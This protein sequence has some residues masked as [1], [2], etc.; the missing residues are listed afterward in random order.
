MRPI[1]SRVA[2]SFNALATSSACARLSSWQGPAMIEIGKSLPNFTDPAAT[3]GAAQIFAFK[4]FVLFRRDHAGQRQSNQAYFAGSNIR[5]A[6]KA[7][8][9]GTTSRPT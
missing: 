3:T 4:G 7:V 8:S 6:P 1:P 9:G 5:V 2:I